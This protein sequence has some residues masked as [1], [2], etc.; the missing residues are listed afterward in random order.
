M[1][2]LYFEQISNWY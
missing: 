2:K 1:A